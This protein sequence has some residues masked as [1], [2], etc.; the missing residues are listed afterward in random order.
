MHGLLDG[1]CDAVHLPTHYGEVVN[2]DMM[3]CCVG[4]AIDGGRDLEMFL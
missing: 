4:M 2:S 3:I 1:S